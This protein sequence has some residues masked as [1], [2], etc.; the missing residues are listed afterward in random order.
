M[1]IHIHNIYVTHKISINLELIHRAILKK[2]RF[3][4]KVK[5]ILTSNIPEIYGPIILPSELNRELSK[6]YLYK[7]FWSHKVN[8]TYS[9]NRWAYKTHF[10][11]FSMFYVF[12]NN[13]RIVIAKKVFFGK[14]RFLCALSNATYPIQIHRAVLEK[15][16]FENKVK[17]TLTSNISEIYGP[18]ILPK[19]LDRELSKIYLYKEFWND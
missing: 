17:K 14:Y 3:E 15:L 6:I 10:F 19:E 16:R 9:R 8:C 5:K 1:K 4:K 13:K 2:L 11:H 12:V 18:I 7:E